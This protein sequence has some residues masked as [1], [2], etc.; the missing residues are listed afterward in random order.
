LLQEVC[1]QCGGYS[2]KSTGDGFFIVFERAEEALRFAFEAQ[3]SL[4]QRPE[5]P[6]ARIGIEIGEVFEVVEPDGNRDYVGP[7]ANRAARICALAAPKTV[8]VSERTARTVAKLPKGSSLESIGNH[9]L[10]NIGLETLFL[11]RHEGLGREHPVAKDRISVLPWAGD[12]FVGRDSK[13]DDVIKNIRKPENRCVTIV[14][15]GGMGK[16]RLSLEAAHKLTTEI[17][18]GIAFAELDGI[19]DTE[20][21][22]S[23]LAGALKT[24]GYEGEPKPQDI[25][26][27]LSSK[28]VLL[29]LDGVEG[30]PRIAEM[31]SGLLSRAKNLKLLLT[32]RNRPKIPSHFIVLESLSLPDAAT[33]LIARIQAHEPEF[34]PSEDDHDISELCRRLDC[35]PLSLELAAARSGLM[36]PREMLERIES[37]FSWMTDSEAPETGHRRSLEATIAWSYDLLTDSG[38]SAL[39]VASLFPTGFRLDTWERLMGMQSLDALGEL[40]R[41]S[42]IS[43]ETRADRLGKVFCLLETIRFYAAGRL[44]ADPKMRSSFVARFACDLVEQAQ[45]SIA[46]CRTPAEASA[47]RTLD[48]LAPNLHSALGQLCDLGSN[49]QAASVCEVLAAF[50]HY[51]GRN[52]Q[53]RDLATQGLSLEDGVHDDGRLVRAGLLRWLSS[54]ALD[55]GDAPTCAQSAFTL[56]GLAASLPA[57]SRKREQARA[58]ILTGLAFT[59]SVEPKSATSEFDSA[60]ALAVEL[61]DKSL[62]GMV[63]HNMGWLAFTSGELEDA[64]RYL[65]TARVLREGL[66]DVRGIAE[67]SCNMGLLEQERGNLSSALTLHFRSLSC[68]SSVLDIEGIGKALFNLAETFELQ[69]S[70]D[71]ARAYYAASLVMFERSESH[72]IEYPLQALNRLGDASS[73]NEKLA[74]LDPT[75]IIE[76]LQSHFGTGSKG[77]DS[78]SH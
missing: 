68:W 66:G 53:A 2:V 57:A 28:Q 32:S 71:V 23:I 29:I 49:R 43:T 46:L 58:H 62:E 19:R 20:V 12:L 35:I 77:A 73:L 24:I 8:L 51:C 44:K 18:D 14:G 55:L 10:R 36:S 72:H 50:N 59:A 11:L 34:T 60:L 41:S 5:L 16:T 7:A 40:Q 13:L 27:F 25:G 47:L 63:R 15:L 54:A 75:N 1:Q 38:K 78:A 67:T 30:L 21:G 69:Q 26:A 31:V 4:S 64:A 70:P 3:V 37:R 9:S 22:W 65:E 52:R 48:E 45:R 61:G 42:L 56:L 74:S 76:W 39:K 17:L 6:C 33:L